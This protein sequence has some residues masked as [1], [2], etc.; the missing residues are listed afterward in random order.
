MIATLNIIGAGK[1]GKVLGQLFHRL[2]V[3]SVQDVLTRS[4]S[5]STDACKFIGT[6]HAVTKFSAL[7]AAAVFM[8]TVPDDQIKTCTQQLRQH[9]LIQADTIVFHCS[10][11]LSSDELELGPGAASLHP[12]RSFANPISVAKNFSGTVCTLEG[13]PRAT[14]FLTSALEQLGARTVSIEKEAKTLYHAGAVFASNYL[15]TLLDAALQTFVTAGISPEMAAR[16]VQ[17]LAQ[18]T[19]NNVFDLGTQ[20]A[21]TGPIARGDNRTV[22]RHEAALS[23][24]DDEI[25]A[26]YQEL[27]NATRKMKNRHEA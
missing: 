11:A 23:S 27:A 2:H 4:P 20:R 18:E 10:G 22:A 19:F 5:S 6:G 26:L 12:L 24:W 7:R 14:A 13:D 25:A 21:L 3:F 8:I 1:V 15:V 16:M 9:G 17:P